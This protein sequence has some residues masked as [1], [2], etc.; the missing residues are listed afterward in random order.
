MFPQLLESVCLQ[1]ALLASL[2]PVE[3]RVSI[4][5]FEYLYTFTFLQLII[6]KIFVFG[7]FN[8][9]RVLFSVVNFMESYI[10]AHV[11]NLVELHST[12]SM[13]FHV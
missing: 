11:L 9:P 2:P 7:I 8:A 5:E 12:R 6:S 3:A 13:N 1:P 4:C 10:V